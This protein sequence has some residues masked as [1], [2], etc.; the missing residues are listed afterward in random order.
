MVLLLILLAL[1]SLTLL[2]WQTS[3][4]IS[5]FAGSP[6]VKTNRNVIR[7]ALKLVN[8]K[9]GEVFYE[10]GSGN[11][12][13]LIAAAKLGAKAY[14][15]EISP[16]YFY[17]SKFRTRKFKNIQIFQKSFYKINFKKAEVAYCYLLPNVLRDLTS[18]FK[19]FKSG[20]R[21]IS[22]GFPI[23]HSQAKKT[24]KHSINNHKIF[25]YKY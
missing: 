7:E 16:F 20:S 21:L 11:G 15:F 25:I 18:K 10:L 24:E 19:D 1:L 17:W 5:A 8:I 3:N 12:D 13:V 9:K 23:K 22:I 6:Y 2:F 4:I 14:G